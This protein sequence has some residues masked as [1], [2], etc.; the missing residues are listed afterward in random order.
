MPEV[1]GYA[2]HMN[3]VRGMGDAGTAHAY[4]TKFRLFGSRVNQALL[5]AL[6]LYGPSNIMKICAA[7]GAVTTRAI[8]PLVEAGMVAR[9]SSR[10]GRTHDIFSLNAA[11]PTYREL[12]ALLRT[13]TVL[14]D[15]LPFRRQRDP[16]DGPDRA[17]LNPTR[18]YLP[19]TLFGVSH[20]KAVANTLGMLVHTPNEEA[21]AASVGRLVGHKNHPTSSP[22]AMRR[23]QKLGIVASRKY[24]TMLLYR[25]DESWPAYA[26]LRDLIL[27]M[28]RVWNEYVEGA[29]VEFRLFLPNRKAMERGR[30]KAAPAG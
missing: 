10:K 12:R 26:E 5:A 18:K 1:S 9:I 11:H 21:E 19:Y 23:L 30:T 24:K 3:G 7:A 6:A 28:G 8:D 22:K 16:Y 14:D 2:K 4:G 29:G 17:A 25:L 27:A 15:S 20:K 13:P